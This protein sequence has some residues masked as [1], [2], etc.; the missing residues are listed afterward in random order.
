MDPE[1][2][3]LARKLLIGVGG[4][5]AV[6]AVGLGVWNSISNRPPKFARVVAEDLPA[7]S[8]GLVAFNDPAHLLE[9]F[10]EAIPADV[11]AELEKEL[12]F[13]PFS[14]SSYAELGFD[15]S[16]PI[17]GGVVGIEQQVFVFTMGLDD[18]SKARETIEDYASKAGVNGWEKREFA[19][20]DGMWLEEPPVAVLF[21]GDRLIVV[22][23]EDAEKDEVE[24]VAD[25][26]AELRGRDSLAS[27]TAFRSV[28]RFEGEPIMLGFFNVAEVGSTMMAAMTIGS[29]DVECMA[30]ALTHDDEDIHFISQ[31]TVSKDSDYLRYLDGGDRS[32][33]ALDRVPAP[34]YAGMHWSIDPEYL[35]ALL[36]ELGTLG[37]SSF[38]DAQRE[39]ESELG[40]NFKQDVLEAWT[41]EFG[42]LWTGAGEDH[43]GGLGF[44]GVRDED[45][46]ADTLERVWQKTEGTE[47][48]STNAGTLFRWKEEAAAKVW[49]ERLWVGFGDSHIEQVNDD[50]EAFRKS[51]KNEAVTGVIES[52][53]NG[54][55]FVDLVAIFAM[56]RE[57][58]PEA[59]E[60][61][62]RHA[63]VIDP[64]QAV[65]MDSVVDGQTF[66]WT[67]TLHTNVDDAWDTLLKRLI[68]NVVE[69]EGK[70]LFADVLPEAD[71]DATV[72]HMVTL[73]MAETPDLDAQLVEPVRAELLRMCEE[74][75]ID[76]RCALAATNVQELDRCQVE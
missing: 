35:R 39:A 75:K 64:L 42:V 53:S 57:Q 18:A 51:S 44:V 19:G 14:A 24:R 28:Q 34:V 30:F 74:G 62:D 25:D 60:W 38:E 15:V 11:R 5:T 4:L 71:C 63:D 66:T 49:D 67:M 65:T 72:A 8:V 47:R 26:I 12:D 36:D 68:T 17:G 55:A 22:G 52:G 41:G 73:T 37:K 58:E 6:A 76:K 61:L 40:V 20:V 70:E 69:H 56:L 46:A 23:S 27:T 10:N 2:K 31:T 50:A 32:L 45:K 7:E 3:V 29:T 21:R 59:G 54:I 9:L 13:D 33:R 16:A 1:R 48:E 43:W